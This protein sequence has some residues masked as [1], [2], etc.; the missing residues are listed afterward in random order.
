[1]TYFFMQISYKFEFTYAPQSQHWKQNICHY[2][3]LGKSAWFSICRDTGL[4]GWYSNSFLHLIQVVWST[5]PPF[6]RDDLTGLACLSPIS[7]KASR[8]MM[9]F[10]VA[11]LAGVMLVFL[12]P[13]KVPGLLL[14]LVL[15]TVSVLPNFR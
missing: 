9:A 4:Y 6:L 13:E 8:S 1:M 3:Y 10:T 15:C 2:W 12:R 14:E 7:F 5:S 11:I